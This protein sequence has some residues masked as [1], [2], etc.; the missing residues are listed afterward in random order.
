MDQGGEAYF[1]TLT[2]PIGHLDEEAH[3]RKIHRDLRGFTSDTRWKGKGRSTALIT[4]LEFGTESGHAHGHHLVVAKTPHDAGAVVECLLS[5]WLRRHPKA[6]LIAQ[7]TIGPLKTT[8]EME[9]W[10]SY[11]TKGSRIDPDWTDDAILAAVALMTNGHQP[12]TACGLARKARRP[13]PLE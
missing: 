11:I 10:L 7:D 4:A 12:I 8:G 3:A 6:S 9:H 1:L 2:T 5:R 13:K